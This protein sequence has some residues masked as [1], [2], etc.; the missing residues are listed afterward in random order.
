MVDAQAG[1][2]VGGAGAG[3]GVEARELGAVLA[4]LQRE[5]P[6]LVALP[7]NELRSLV[8]QVT[9]GYVEQDTLLDDPKYMDNSLLC[10]NFIKSYCV[11][12]KSCWN[13]SLL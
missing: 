3:G 5:V 4:Y 10:R 8:L 12:Y 11:R 13:K 2:D 7:P 1:D 6:S 9:P